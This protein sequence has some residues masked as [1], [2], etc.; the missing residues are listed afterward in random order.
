[1]TTLNIIP[2]ARQQRNIIDICKDKFKVKIRF[3]SNQYVEKSIRKLLCDFEG[4]LLITE[5]MSLQKQTLILAIYMVALE[6]MATLLP[7]TMLNHIDNLVYCGLYNIRYYNKP[8]D[9]NVLEHLNSIE[10]EHIHITDLGIIAGFYGLSENYTERLTQNKHMN[11]YLS[12]FNYLQYAVDPSQVFTSARYVNMLKHAPSSKMFNYKEYVQIVVSRINSSKFLN[13]ITNGFNIHKNGDNYMR[14][15]EYDQSINKI[16]SGQGIKYELF[17][18]IDSFESVSD[19]NSYMYA[20]VM[21]YDFKVDAEFRALT[22]I[23]DVCIAVDVASHFEYGIVLVFPKTDLINHNRVTK[24]QMINRL[25][26]SN[27]DTHITYISSSGECYLYM[28][29][30]SETKQY[31]TKANVFAV[32]VLNTTDKFNC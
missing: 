15:C 30:E 2:L 12:I 29:C 1:M 32:L 20:V 9:S 13:E 11:I 5:N 21:S 18:D 19:A 28:N 3:Q 27:E 14:L 25:S 16:T 22:L 24:Y 31:I 17:S 7:Q 10:C 6:N 4:R 8:E 23:D 26:N